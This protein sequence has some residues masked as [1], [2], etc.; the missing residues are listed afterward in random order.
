MGRPAP[1]IC[2]EKTLGILACATRESKNVTRELDGCGKRNSDENPV[3][4]CTDEGPEA[5]TTCDVQTTRPV[6]LVAKQT[7][8][9]DPETGDRTS[10]QAISSALER[11]RRKNKTVFLNLEERGGLEWPP[12]RR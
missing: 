2:I 3:T 6:C 9:G 4:R 10:H 8:Y 5:D 1:H 7:S 12:V 11:L